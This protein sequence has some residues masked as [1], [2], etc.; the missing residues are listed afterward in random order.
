MYELEA[1]HR[2]GCNI[3]KFRKHHF[4]AA[5]KQVCFTSWRK[6]S[7]S[8][9]SYSSKHGLG[10]APGDDQDLTFLA[11]E[12]VCVFLH[13]CSGAP[14]VPWADYHKM[15]VIEQFL[16]NRIWLEE[17]LKVWDQ[18]PRSFD[19]WWGPLPY[20][21]HFLGSLCKLPQTSLMFTLNHLQNSLSHWWL[22]FGTRSLGRHVQPTAGDIFTMLFILLLGSF[23]LKCMCFCFNPKARCPFEKPGK[24]GTEFATTTSSQA[25][26]ILAVL[27]CT[28]LSP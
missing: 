22:R 7:I 28:N 23:I 14:P 25:L 6:C 8:C 20:R 24:F 11:Q 13:G 4:S 18:D 17:G 12:W 21:W 3:C 15:P 5:F 16:S 26:V 1:A 2:V 9:Q 27:I 19:I 10:D